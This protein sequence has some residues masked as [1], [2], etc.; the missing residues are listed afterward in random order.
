[1]VLPKSGRT[2]RGGDR[3]FRSCVNSIGFPLYAY[4]RKKGYA[5][6]D[7]QD[8]VQGFFSELIEKDFLAA[9]EQD[10][11]R[12]RWFLMSAASRYAANW[13][14][15]E[16][17]VKRGGGK[18]VFSLDFEAGE[19]KYSMEPANNQ[20]PEKL[21]ERQWALSLLDQAI[22]ELKSRYETDGKA[23]YFEKLKVYLTADSTAPSHKE[24]ASALGINET[25]VKV[26]IY[27]LREK[28]RETIRRI[29][30]Q[31]LADPE[32]LDDE[33]SRLLESLS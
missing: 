15:Q 27:R 28:Y 6:A 12:F 32:E 11:G 4:L 14:K 33:I 16:K 7:A 2:I 10:K 9:V 29:V 13:V 20:T 18:A 8:L 31:T 19:Q 3:H 1:M 30:A 24:T 25:T 5:S 21:F 17:A 26:A 22:S 23:A